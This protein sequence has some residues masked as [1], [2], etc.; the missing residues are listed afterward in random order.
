MEMTAQPLVQPSVTSPAQPAGAPR[1]E[2]EAEA[3][4]GAGLTDSGA[5]A[6]I[7]GEMR[8]DVRVLARG[9]APAI[10][11]VSEEAE[12]AG[13][14]EQEAD[15][16]SSGHHAVD[17]TSGS[18]APPAGGA[19]VFH[20][21]SVTSPSL[22]V[23][24]LPLVFQSHQTGLA[25]S[26]EWLP[27]HGETIAGQYTVANMLG[28]GNFGAT[29]LCHLTHSPH[30]TQLCL[31]VIHRDKDKLDSSLDEVRTLRRIRGADASYALQHLIDV[32]YWRER[33]I[34]VT[35]YHG[36][37][38]DELCE[39]QSRDTRLSF[40]LP[41]GIH[42]L[43]QQ[44]LA[45]LA[46]LHG[47]GITHTD[48]KPAN[49]CVRRPTI[50]TLI[51]FGAV[52]YEGSTRN[53]GMQPLD[54]RAPEVILGVPWGAAVDVWSLGC[55]LVEMLL[56]RVL[57]Q[58]DLPE[59]VLASQIALVGPLPGSLRARTNPWMYAII[60]EAT[61]VPGLAGSGL[62]VPHPTSLPELL[63]GITGDAT[64]LELL[65]ALLTMDPDERPTPVDALHH[66]ALVGI[67]WPTRDDGID[68]LM[69]TFTPFCLD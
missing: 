68:R 40:F 37:S 56:G 46:Y 59:G 2:A 4:G 16:E 48:V 42:A 27:R 18:S 23:A 11:R 22:E 26:A 24:W 43:A 61:A 69:R 53:S 60:A 44:M 1:V 62:V 64:L 67:Q 14:A 13:D 50:F 30:S 6:G 28:S 35:E 32:F 21:Q 19:V 47:L 7:R 5:W 25:S 10:A 41:T 63:D 36:C 12:E 45:A 9:V 34:I 49:I 17:N 3:A 33:L 54:H 57:F 39:T 8:A 52:V 20:H 58:A 65:N 15:A 31:K 55:V 29:F 51:D 38:L 66:P